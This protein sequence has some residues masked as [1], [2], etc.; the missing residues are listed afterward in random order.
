M[1]RFLKRLLDNVWELFAMFIGWSIIFAFGIPITFFTVFLV[2]ILG[3]IFGEVIRIFL[4][5]NK[6]GRK[7]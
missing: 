1:E 5:K 6:I 3:Y 4:W 7:F 2:T